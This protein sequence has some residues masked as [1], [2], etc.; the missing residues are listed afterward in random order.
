MEGPLSSQPVLARNKTTW[1]I[2]GNVDFAQGHFSCIFL[3]IFQSPVVY[4]TELRPFLLKLNVEKRVLSSEI[5]RII[6]GVRLVDWLGRGLI[7][8]QLR[9]VL[10]VVIMVIMVVMF[11]MVAFHLFSH[12]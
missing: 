7:V 6:R 2:L 11:L 1:N 10:V 4:L 5:K 3:N 9:T 8:P 12:R